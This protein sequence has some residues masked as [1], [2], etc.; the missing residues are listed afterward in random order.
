MKRLLPLIA[1]ASFI[2]VACGVDT[3]GLS[4]KSSRTA[5]PETS[6]NAAVQVV[7][8]GDLQCPACKGAH[9]TVVKPLIAK[10]G[11]QIRYDYMHFPLQTLHPYAL[12]AAQASECAADQGKFWQFVDT[13]YTNQDQLNRDIVKQWAKDIGVGDQALF[14]R[15]LDSG[16]K[17]DEI[18]EEYQKGKDVGVQG[19]PTFFV[20][21]K[22]VESGLSELS[23]AI[24]AA[25]KAP[26][27][28]L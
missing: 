9:E 6:A 19:T 2:L 15:C 4:A 18:L 14:E 20:N 11:K 17:K 8:F 28:K 24:D 16:I 5:H 27:Q 1:S 3:T 13:D 25:L 26:A 21:G 7:E 10:Y 22:K 23:A 12:I